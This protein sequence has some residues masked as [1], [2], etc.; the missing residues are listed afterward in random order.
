[1]KKIQIFA[2]NG[3]LAGWWMSDGIDTLFCPL[4][5]FSDTGAG[6][7]A[8]AISGEETKQSNQDTLDAQQTGQEAARKDLQ[9]QYAIS[10]GWLEDQT[11]QNQTAVDKQNALLSGMYGAQESKN[12]AAVAKQSQTNT[13]TANQQ[14]QLNAAQMNAQN[15]WLQRN[16]NAQN[17]TNTLLNKQS[18]AENSALYQPWIK[19]GTDA[20]KAIA[21]IQGLNGPDAQAAAY[22]A[23]KSDPGF[24]YRVD[25]ANQSIER[26]ASARGGL[27]SGATGIALQENSQNMASDE[28]S[29]SFNRLLSVSNQGLSASGSLASLNT[30]NTQYYAGLN[31]ANT[32]NNASMRNT[33]EN[34]LMNLNTGNTMT[35]AGWNNTNA[36]NLMSQNN[37]NMNNEANYLNQNNIGQVDRANATNYYKIGLGDTYGSNMANIDLGLAANQANYYQAQN[38]NTTNTLNSAANYADDS[39][40]YVVST[41]ANVAGSVY[42]SS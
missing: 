3:Q 38:Q 28:F 12:N 22:A 15:E 32:Q 41:A 35:A 16:T 30:G 6:Y 11:A 9:D 23:Y 5:R 27:F 42:G 24:Q 31:N 25:M 2:A 4:T 34:S 29:N 14:N 17:N 1:M 7:V 8:S 18:N 26:S 21:D 10:Q 19:S 40:K 33:N 20:N 13:S 37:T 39:S 36:N